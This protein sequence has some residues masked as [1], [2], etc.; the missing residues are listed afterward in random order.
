MVFCVK[1]EVCDYLEA[2]RADCGRENAL[3]L[4]YLI[5]FTSISFHLISFTSFSAQMILHF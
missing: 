5:S 1:K 3:C 4:L 2:R